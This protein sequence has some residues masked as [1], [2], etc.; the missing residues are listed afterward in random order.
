MCDKSNEMSPIEM[1]A[2]TNTIRG[3]SETQLQI[4]VQNIP[5]KVMCEEIA[6]RYDFLASKIDSITNIVDDVQSNV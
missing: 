4:I 5:I 6:N 3:M 1:E 2:L